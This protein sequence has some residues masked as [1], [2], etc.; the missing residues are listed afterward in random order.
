MTTENHISG[1]LINFEPPPKPQRITQEVK[2]KDAES[3]GQEKGEGQPTPKKPL[4]TSIIRPPRPKPAEDGGS[5]KLQGNN[6]LL[7]SVGFEMLYV[8]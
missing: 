7:Y 6:I 8:L 4:R 1:D 5:S 2:D 3:Q